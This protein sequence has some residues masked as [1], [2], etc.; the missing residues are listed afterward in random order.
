MRFRTRAYVLIFVIF[1]FPLPSSQMIF[2][3]QNAQI[4]YSFSPFTPENIFSL[5]SPDFRNPNEKRNLLDWL[6]LNLQLDEGRHNHYFYSVYT[7]SGEI[8]KISL[9]QEISTLS[10][11]IVSGDTPLFVNDLRGGD[12]VALQLQNYTFLRENDY[13]KENKIPVILLV[14]SRISGH[15][16]A[17]NPLTSSVVASV[18]S[19]LSSFDCQI[20]SA[21]SSFPFLAVE[22]PYCKLFNLAQQDFVSHVFLDTKVKPYLDESVPLIKPPTDWNQLETQFGFPINGSGV[23]IAILDSGIDT[24]HPDLDDFDDDPLTTDSKVIAESCFTGEGYTHDN[25]GHGTHCASIAAGTGNASSYQYVGVAPGAYLLNGKVIH[26]LGYGTTSW[27]ISGIEW[28]VSQSADIISMSFGSDPLGG[29]GNGTDPLSLTVDWA[30]SQGV[31][32]TIAAGRYGSWGEFSIAAPGVAKLAIT[33]GATNQADIVIP[34]SSRGPTGDY[35]LKPDVCAPGVSII[36]ARA[37]NS[38]M[39]TPI[40]EFYTSATGTSM[41]TPHVAGAAALILQTHPTW[42]PLMIKSALMGNAKPLENTVL[43]KQGAGRIQICEALNTSLLIVEPSTS[44]GAFN[45]TAISVN[46]TLILMNLANTPIQVSLSTYTQCDQLETNGVSV[47][48]SSISIPA[49]TNRSI[50]LSVELNDVAPGGFYQGRIT[51]STLQNNKT[52]PYFFIK[53]APP[54]W[55]QLPTNQ[56]AEYG[57][58]LHYELEA[59]DRDGL[60]TWWVN[61]TAS[62]SIDS[63]GILTNQTELEVINYG[64]QVWVNDTFNLI[65]TAT[66]SITVQDTISPV[67]STTPTNQELAYGETLGYRVYAT[68]LSGITQWTIDDLTNFSISSSGL[69]TNNLLLE[70][71][72]YSV[73]ITVYDAHGNSLSS[74]IIIT[75][76]AIAPPPPVPGFP[77][78]SILLG[79]LFTIIPL[80]FIRAKRRT[81]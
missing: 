79:C 43:W 46:T 37:N 67:W 36:A 61:D 65:L 10:G 24:N 64:I 23:R 78:I 80:V 14:G 66:F 63:S 70:P 1:L 4:I 38:D 11:K 76:E 5:D 41:A 20:I 59:S 53:M 56:I 31:I 51:F 68:D 47:N 35:R 49:L 45:N 28:A 50:L 6:N 73:T 77:W 60:D 52:A 44:F 13:L 57:Y 17:L 39:G 3:L 81:R 27:S 55:N 21:F 74:T 69:L 58:I 32:C 54:I 72:E 19:R 40:N 2:F 15:A 9:Q 33:V 25:R 42:N 16:Y 75:V 29:S 34:S 62:F 12:K 71:G 26:D 18:G 22:L 8:M 48:E 30:V 7:S